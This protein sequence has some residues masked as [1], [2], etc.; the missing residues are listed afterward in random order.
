MQNTW[1]LDSLLNGKSIEDLF[2]EY[3]QEQTKIIE[4]YKTFLANESNFINFLQAM[5]DFKCLSNRLVNYLT[6]N[7][8]E[9]LANQVWNA[10]L[11]KL[12]LQN[13][14]FNKV[15]SNYDNLVIKNKDKIKTYLLNPTISEY[16]IEF[17]RIFRYEPYLLTDKEE[18]LLSQIS[19]YN[20]GIDDIYA[21]LTDG[22]LKFSPAND[23]NGNT[24]EIKTQADVFKNL[25]SHD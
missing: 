6:N 14:E 9:D 16:T 10:W 2:N 17:E 23:K 22:D 24:I 12:N 7:Y 3:V 11:Q 19:S 25:K 4:L 15:F 21:T 5:E 13:L 1:D 20:G 8:Q 18:M